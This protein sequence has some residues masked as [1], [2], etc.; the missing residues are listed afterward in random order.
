MKHIYCP[1]CGSLETNCETYVGI[2]FGI[3]KSE[4]MLFTETDEII[5]SIKNNVRNNKRIEVECDTC[6]HNFTVGV[7]RSSL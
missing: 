6:G 2:N 3:R 7:G 1:N 4:V 5:N